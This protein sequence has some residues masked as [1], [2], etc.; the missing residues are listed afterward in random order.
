VTLARNESFDVSGEVVEFARFAGGSD[1]AM[2]AVFEAFQVGGRRAV[3]TLA[4]IRGFHL[5]WTESDDL[6]IHDDPD[7]VTFQSPT[8]Q[9]GKVATGS[10]GCDG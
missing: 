3:F 5:D 6:P 9:F 4:V 2:D 10:R 8:Q 7:I 1:L